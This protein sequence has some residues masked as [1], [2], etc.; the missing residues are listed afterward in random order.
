M[1]KQ[2][3]LRK[4]LLEGGQCGNDEMIL[5]QFAAQIIRQVRRVGDDIGGRQ[6]TETAE[7]SRAH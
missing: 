7:Q 6:T 5:A 4:P 3:V 2:T 1:A